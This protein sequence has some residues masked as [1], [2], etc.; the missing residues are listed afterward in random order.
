LQVNPSAWSFVLVV[1]GWGLLKR[2]ADVGRLWFSL[3]ALIALLTV[4]ALDHGPIAALGLIG[5]IAVAITLPPERRTQA[6]ALVGVA[7]A[8]AFVLCLCW[9]WF[10]IWTALISPQDRDYWFNPHILKKELTIWTG[11]AVL[12]SLAVATLRPRALN[13]AFLTA[14]AISFTLGLFAFPLR[15]PTLERLP[16]PAIFFLHLPIALFL[17]ETRVFSVAS[18]PARLRGLIKGGAAGAMPALETAVAVLVLVL[19][20]PQL[21]STLREPHL[22]R[23]PV[24]RL[25]HRPDKQQNIKRRLDALLAPVGHHDVVLSDVLTSWPVPSSA[26]R[27]VAPLHFEMFVNNQPDRVHD[28]EA[29]FTT[30]TPDEQRVIL[31]RYRVRWVLLDTER[32]SER[33]STALQRDWPTVARDRELVLL[34]ARP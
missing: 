13:R 17:T 5:L 28:V 7:A 10:S 3:P 24:A 1:F 20:T 2:A 8:L 34:D 32:I 25:L 27:I 22:L 11:P 30:A 33:T 4:T 29:F 14:A 23:G 19:L 15:S 12:C 9:P 31:Q 18:W 6:L 26:G 21:I 16:L